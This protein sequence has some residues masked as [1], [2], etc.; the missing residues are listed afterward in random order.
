VTSLSHDWRCCKT[1]RDLYS[2][3][4]YGTVEPTIPL[5]SGP[6]AEIIDELSHGVIF[7]RR[8]CAGEWM[9]LT[10]AAPAAAAV[11]ARTD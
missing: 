7:G 2:S 5:T 8:L 4:G 6:P 1:R 10:A 3:Q 9:P 11:A